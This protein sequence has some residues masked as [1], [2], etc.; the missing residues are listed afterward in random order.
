MPK[1]YC[2][3]KQ[4]TQNIKW[5]AT[6]WYCIRHAVVPE[7]EHNNTFYGASDVG[8][9]PDMDLARWQ[10]SIL[11]QDNVILVTSALK[12]TTQTAQA[13]RDCGFALPESLVFDSLNEMHFGYW[14][15]TPASDHIKNK[16][17]GFWYAPA[18]YRITDG[19]SFADLYA[20]VSHTVCA[21]TLQHAGKNIISVTHGGTIRA[22][23]AY[24]LGLPIKTAV[25]INIDNQSITL[26]E[27]FHSE[28]ADGNIVEQN[29]WRVHYINKIPHKSPYE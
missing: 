25:D 21:V 18:H 13:L 1:P 6:R 17:H 3:D 28:D 12:R 4:M 19:E 22:Q 7:C 10:T 24:A 16:K 29:K 23:I 5:I 14:Q 9:I 26:L 27:H 15:G 2:K 8:C 20:R 11:P